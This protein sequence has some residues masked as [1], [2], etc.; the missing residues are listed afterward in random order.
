ML[1]TVVHKKLEKNNWV[2]VTYKK[3][4]KSCTGFYLVKDCKYIQ[5]CSVVDKKLCVFDFN[6][7]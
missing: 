2:E 7:T 6:Y 4:A 3:Y 1:T 5:E